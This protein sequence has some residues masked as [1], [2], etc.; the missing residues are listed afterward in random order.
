MGR[1]H[2]RPATDEHVVQPQHHYRTNNR[3]DRAIEVEAGHWRTT[4]GGED[5]ASDHRADYSENDVENKALPGAVDD[6]AGDEA[7]DEAQYQPSEN[8]HF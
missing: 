8:G 1:L 5:E 4:E 7:R 6:L 2:S 3:D